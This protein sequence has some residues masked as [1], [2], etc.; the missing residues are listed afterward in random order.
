[1]RLRKFIRVVL[2]CLI[3]II[4]VVVLLIISLNLPFSKR[5]VTR[6]VNQLFNN[7]ELPIHINSIRTLRLKTVNL[8]GVIISDLQGDTIIYAGKV[9]ADYRLL[10]LLQKKVVLKEADLR[11]VSMDLLMNEETRKYTIAETFRSGKRTKTEQ[12]EG[13]RATWEISIK[14]GDLS[15]I[16]FRMTDSIS[17]I[18][19]LQ[20]ID[21]IQLKR[22][23]ISLLDREIVAHT[24]ALSKAA[25]NI[26]LTPYPPR[27]K[28]KQ[29]GSPWNFGVRNLFMNEINFTYHQ[30]SD[31]L[32]LH[33]I[34]R[35]GVIG[36]N[37]IDLP[38][39]IVDIDKI[40]FEGASAVIL[41][42][43]RS[44]V[45][46]ES[47]GR[48]NNNFLWDLRTDKIDLE[49][50]AVSA[51]SYDLL[52]MS[53]PAI[54]VGLDGLEMKLRDFR[55]NMDHAGVEVKKL[56]FDMDNGFVMK[57]M[58]GAFHSDPETTR[59]NLALETGNSC[60]NLTG[61]AEEGLYA[62]I[63]DPEEIRKAHI[64][65]SNTHISP[66][67]IAAFYPDLQGYPF[68]TLLATLPVTIAGHI[69]LEKS[70]LRFPD[71]SI[72]QDQNFEI[73][74]SGMAEQPFHPLQ[75][76]GDVNLGIPHID[77]AW[78][79]Q[80]LK[81]FGI[82]KSIPD[83][84]K[85]SLESRISGSFRSPKCTLLLQSN[86]GTIDLSGSLNYDNK[87]Y[88]LISTF[89]RLSL[90]EILAI[91]ELGLLT[92]SGEITG[93]GYTLETLQASLSLW[94]D[95][96]R[97]NGY[98]Y[99][100]INIDGMLRPG[101]YGV[102]ILANDPSFKGDLNVELYHA[103]SIFEAQVTGTVFARLN[104]LHFLKDTL[105]VESNISA[106]LIKE[107]NVLETDLT[108]AGMTLTTS[109]DSAKVSQISLSFK[110]DSV[111]TTLTGEADFFN[112]D[113]QVE[114]PFSELE[115]LGEAYGNYLA[116][117]IDHNHSN[118]VIRVSNLPEIYATSNITKHKVLRLFTQNRD[119]YIRGLDFSLINSPSENR[120][121][122]NIR[123]HGMEYK[124]AKA[125]E[126][127]AT[128]T[129]SAGVMNLQVIMDSIS[130]FSG[131]AN[132]LYL[133][134]RFSEWQSMTGLSIID[135]LDTVVYGF[136]IASEVDSNLV[137][138]KIPSKQMILNREEWHMDSPDL[139][140]YDLTTQ[141][142]SP[143][144]KMHTDSSFLHSHA[145]NK[146][147]LYVYAIE[148][149]QV[150]ITSLFRND[151]V[152][153]KPGGYISG[154]I[155]YSTD[156]DTE[157]RVTTDLRFRDARFSDLSFS[158][159]IF[160]GD[161][162]F[163]DSGDYSIDMFAQL[164]SSR[165]MFNGDQTD[166]G[167]RNITAEFSNIHINTIQPFTEDY[168]S[169][170]R[171]YLS[172]SLNIS[173]LEGREQFGGELAFSDAQLKINALNSKYTIPDQSILVADQRM[174][175]N[176]FRVLDSLDKPLLVDGYVDFSN[177]ELVTT[178]LDISSSKLQVMNRGE[179]KD[180]S[181][182]GNIFVD[183]K[184]FVKG[185]LKNPTI[186]GKILLS[187]GTEIYYRHLDDL[188]LSESEEI[189]TFVS[190]SSPGEIAAPTPVVGRSAFMESSIETI[191]EIDPSTILNFNLSKRIFNTE[192][193]IKGGGLLNYNMLNNSQVTLSGIYNISEGAAELRLIGWPNKSFSISK[194]G[195]IR[196][197]GNI[198]DPELKFEAI[199]KV[200]SSYINPLDG[201]HR[202]VDFNVILQL[203]NH[204]SDLDILLSIN[205]ND[206]Y[207]MSIINT[208]SPEE[209]MRQAITI[210]LF[211]IVDL[212]GI[213]TSS[214]YMTQQVNQL[215]ASQLNRLTKSTIKGVDISFGID[216]YVHNTQ[217][218]GEETTTSLSYEVKKSLLD[219]R[220]QIEISG[221]FYDDNQQPGA[222]NVSLN[223]ISFE[224]RL[225]SAATKYLKVYNEHTYE[226]VF[227]G[228]VIETGVGITYRKRYRTFKD[229][230]RR[231]K[232]NGK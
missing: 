173:T 87:S 147:G 21:G 83:A 219:N 63:T 120:I 110:A 194:G 60:F 96:L 146:E 207:L 24:L 91:P 34:L 86:R 27:Q 58:K 225:D 113:V 162:V 220:A 111:R 144:L 5:L 73:T 103:D 184:F 33:M 140:S 189:V 149:D 61:V 32:M 159:I 227:E 229:I 2:K 50:V 131:P 13:E 212:P 104:E 232:K 31:S 41:T 12:T 69:E 16:R 226:D 26:T 204:L 85:L 150:D 211:E 67:D 216:S 92:G 115:T 190:Q 200:A 66:R 46:K 84:V 176:S 153:G 148:L 178:G 182:Y 231:K 171:G 10:A 157:K 192:L 1:M 122:Y 51:G 179:E 99:T 45:P 123:G 161:A 170:L 181:F 137:V 37:Q 126:L 36:T 48:T 71:I 139:L 20:D 106:T 180:V 223:N 93:A 105:A 49:D 72:S 80:F 230:W 55:L 127:N 74:L 76:S 88:E 9:K 35:E 29:T 30:S 43:H 116:S 54:R 95:S 81:G 129:D 198:E 209:Q 160:N 152:P 19:I 38:G 215:L 125:G 186:D 136:E 142:V 79:N 172:G 40:S 4:G 133:K 28:K 210:L 121:N 82:E 201:N 23:K 163:Q 3:A 187:S 217:S 132:T 18:H 77:M 169:D 53:A 90:G 185:P 107:R 134:G 135:T 108:I 203:S 39:K 199:N 14:N 17:G 11:Q 25:G 167:N 124:M 6:Q 218:G 141:T 138:L 228:E 101:E 64:D 8:Q 52:H 177:R 224:Y 57:K 175:F 221:R 59:L 65:V 89:E 208:L 205:T 155:D 15:S 119:F 206:Q 202:D 164:D 118:A 68:Y 195:F 128:L 168:L 47:P 145:L 78:F 98:D 214:D 44:N 156:G 102:N 174:I 154:T 22:F 130:I 197:D 191:V 94:V 7:L 183:S 213:S 117:F 56:S 165:M 196:W 222:S 112:V 188:T 100:L 166:G 114:K 70:L 62:L 143:E 151:L 193:K 42:G 109:R 97:F 75:A 158:N